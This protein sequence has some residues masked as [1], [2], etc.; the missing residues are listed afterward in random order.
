MLFRNMGALG[1]ITPLSNGTM[2]FR[3]T[4][5]EDL[6]TDHSEDHDVLVRCVPCLLGQERPDNKYIHYSKI[7][8]VSTWNTVEVGDD[9]T[10]NRNRIQ[11]VRRSG[12]V[13]HRPCRVAD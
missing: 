10:M 4:G 7:S 5:D 3:S 2:C 6:G 1:L 13:Q 12:P 11:G 9:E 8:A